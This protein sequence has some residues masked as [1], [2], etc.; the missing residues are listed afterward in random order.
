MV[1]GP[2]PGSSVTGLLTSRQ[3]TLANRFCAGGSSCRSTQ[4]V[5]RSSNQTSVS[6]FLR[7]ISTEEKYWA[8]TPTNISELSSLVGMVTLPSTIAAA[9]EQLGWAVGE[10]HDHIAQTHAAPTA[11]DLVGIPETLDWQT[12]RAVQPIGYLL[13][14]RTEVADFDFKGE[15]VAGVGA[16][17]DRLRR[18]PAQAGSA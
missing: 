14:C 5:W 15:S 8:S 2:A 12:G 13:W 6:C 10:P 1:Q 18:E 11:A 3:V 7:G 4:T 9:A 16:I 17:R